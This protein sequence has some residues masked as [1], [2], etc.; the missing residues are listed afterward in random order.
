MKNQIE[1]IEISFPG[2]KALTKPW[3]HILQLD[4]EP[5]MIQGGIIIPE[6]AK[7]SKLPFYK[8]QVLAVGPDVKHVKVGDF[9]I[10]PSQV[11]LTA[12]WDKNVAHYCSEDKILAVVE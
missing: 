2:V 12:K 4:W 6:N 1:G 8:V 3:G 7:S 9:V 10:L 5:Q 11:I